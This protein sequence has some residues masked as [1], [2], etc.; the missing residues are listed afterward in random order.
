MTSTKGVVIMAIANVIF[1]GIMAH[2]AMSM[3]KQIDAST[4]YI[5]TPT[6]IHRP[7]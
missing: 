7:V 5:P 6:A 3:M 2:F 1:F 4:T